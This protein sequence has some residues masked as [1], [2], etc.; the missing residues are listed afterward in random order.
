MLHQVIRIADV[1]QK[2][3]DYGHTQYLNWS[4]EIS[5]SRYFSEDDFRELIELVDSLENE[6]ACLINYVWHCRQKFYHLNL[7][8]NQQLL[9][10]REKLT[11][12]HDDDT[13][14]AGSQLFNLLH[15]ITGRLITSTFLIRKVFKGE[16]VNNPEYTDGIDESNISDDENILLHKSQESD[17]S[18]QSP[19]DSSPLEREIQKLSDEERDIFTELTEEMEYDEVLSLEALKQADECSIY[20]AMTWCNDHSSDSEFLEVLKQKWQIGMPNAGEHERDSYDTV[21]LQQD[22]LYQLSSEAE[23]TQIGSFFY[24]F[25]ADQRNM[26]NTL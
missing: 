21:P 10:L 6:L 4:T 9:L 5:C 22:Q 16:S 14:D 19:V 17:V 1:V 13:A 12:L 3:K 11:K 20:K 23:F 8:T 26:E 24:P 7:Y 2:L 25:V 15:S 18:I